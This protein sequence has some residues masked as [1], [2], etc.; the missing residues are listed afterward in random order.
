VTLANEIQR[1]I[2]ENK[3]DRKYLT[4]GTYKRLSKWGTPY[5]WS[6]REQFVKPR[7]Q[8]ICEILFGGPI[9]RVD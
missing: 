8:R 7:A 6:N 2:T 4:V 1:Q 5:R 9:G 3:A